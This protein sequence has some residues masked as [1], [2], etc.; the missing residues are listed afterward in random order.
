M[1]EYDPEKMKMVFSNILD[2]A[3]KYSRA[4]SRIMIGYRK[5]EAGHLFSVQD[6]GI[7]ISA[8]DKNKIF[9]SFYRTE[10]AKTFSTLGTGLGLYYVK[11]VIDLHQGK[12]WF[13]SEEN[14]GTT[15]YIALK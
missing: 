3:I 6:F 5:D 11:K 12:I 7:G 8:E 4:N 13:E 15:F 1:L 10:Q 14:K 9:S 2:N